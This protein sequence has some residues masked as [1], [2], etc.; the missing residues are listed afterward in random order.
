[1]P[2]HDGHPGVAC[3]FADV[4]LEL[5][6]GVPVPRVRREFRELFA[7]RA[8]DIAAAVTAKPAMFAETFLWD[9]A[10]KAA[11]DFKLKT[12]PLLW[13]VVAQ[14]QGDSRPYEEL[15]AAYLAMSHREHIEWYKTIAASPLREVAHDT[16]ANSLESEI[17]DARSLPWK[18]AVVVSLPFSDAFAP[19]VGE[20]IA[21]RGG[22]VG[23]M[24]VE[25]ENL[26]DLDSLE[27]ELEEMDVPIRA[28]WG[29]DYYLVL[30]FSGYISDGPPTEH[31]AVRMARDEIKS[32]AGLCIACDFVSVAEDT[33]TWD[34]FPAPIF[35][36]RA[37]GGHRGRVAWLPDDE[38]AVLSRL[39]ATSSNNTPAAGHSKRFWHAIE[40]A[41]RRRDERLLNAAR[42]LFGS[43]CGSNQLLSLV[44]ATV[45]LEI[46]LG[47]KKESSDLGIS[48]LV[49]NRAA[50]LIGTSAATREELLAEVKQIYDAR[51]RIVHS[52]RN[53]LGN[54]AAKL[55]RIRSICKQVLQRELAIFATV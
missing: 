31:P 23:Q 27:L 28:S 21:F 9:A 18:Y 50:Y 55:D 47:D 43:Y 8:P 24:S 15:S 48:K 30:D 34:V 53:D 22:R 26:F 12:A 40:A 41:L 38:T 29:D 2:A 17:A 7:R 32:L 13:A 20:G 3:T 4:A 42:W 46:L 10:T 36:F 45:A 52:G 14:Q 11:A 33:R 6:E 54:D 39:S 1:M 51:S 37:D 5:L 25:D 19:Y 49:A 35:I 16:L 44:Q